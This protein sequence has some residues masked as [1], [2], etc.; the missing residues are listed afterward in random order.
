MEVLSDLIPKLHHRFRQ[1]ANLVQVCALSELRPSFAISLRQ[2]SSTG[3]LS[4]KIKGRLGTSADGGVI[5]P[6]LCVA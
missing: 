3:L 1:E 2:S 5:A 4:V 6:A